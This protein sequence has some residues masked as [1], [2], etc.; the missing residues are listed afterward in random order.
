VRGER[1]NEEGQKGTVDLSVL[2]GL[3]GRSFALYSALGT[4]KASILTLAA[5]LQCVLL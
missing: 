3:R 5:Y 2:A 4:G 1:V